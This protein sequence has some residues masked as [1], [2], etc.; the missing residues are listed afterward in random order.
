MER[1]LRKYPF[2]ITPF[3]Y[4]TVILLYIQCSLI[5]GTAAF[6]SVYMISSV[7]AGTAEWGTSLRL[8]ALSI[9]IAGGYFLYTIVVIFVVAAVCFIFRL[10]IEEGSHY[11][12]STGTL[13]WANYNSLILIVR[14]TCMNFLRVTPFLILFYRMMGAKIGKNVQINTC[15]IADCALLEIGDNTVIGG[16]VTLIAH[17]AEHNQLVIKKVKIGSNV[18]LGLMSVIMPG[19]QIGDRVMVAANAVVRK[20]TVM[21]SDTVWGGGPCQRDSQAIMSGTPELKFYATRDIESLPQ[22]QK[23]SKSDRFD[24]KV[25][26]HVL[27]FRVNNYIIENLIDW[28]NVPNDPIYQLTFMQPGMLEPAHFS[29]MADALKAGRP[30]QEINKIADDIRQQLNPH[31]AGQLTANIPKM[32]GEEVP[33]VQHKYRTT[34]LIFPKSG[35]TC[36]SYCTFCFRWPQF[37]GKMDLKFATDE[38]QRFQEYIKRK[39]YITDIILTGGDP[40]IMRSPKLAAYIEPFLKP[41]FDHIQNIRIGTKVLGHWPYRFLTDPDSDALLHLFEKVVKA[42]KHLAL[43]AHFSHAV[44]LSTEPVKKAI[45]KIQSTG[46]IIRTQSPVLRHINDS[47]DVWAKMWS[48]QVKLGCIPYYMFVERDTGSK[49]YFEIPLCQVWEIFQGACKQLSGLARTVR[50]PSMSALP[51]KIRIGGVTE[52][53]G[54]KVFVLEFLQARN[55]EWAKRPFFAKFDA[56]AT[57]LDQLQPAFGEKKFF[58]E[59]E[60]NEHLGSTHSTFF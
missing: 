38:S 16:D 8:L 28:A 6:P 19:V 12:Y 15:V 26:A 55:V 48:E 25:V 39:K 37:V 33:G 60:L 14:Y 20:D 29:K 59:D 56:K 23:V 7:W 5:I 35:Q 2:I 21:P 57:W 46:A 47:A 1:I 24:M 49:N 40:L 41:E 50:G 51:G 30:R 34:C 32:D 31:P 36:F 4:V 52:I 10:K 22:L 44:E 45:K 53:K 17:L 9:S 3:Q 43:M 58:F 54:E 42:G 27:P 13:K 18:T 11:I